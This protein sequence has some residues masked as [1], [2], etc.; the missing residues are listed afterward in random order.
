[1]RSSARPGWEKD[2]PRNA[3][4]TPASARRSSSSGSVSPGGEPD[5]RDR[6]VGRRGFPVALRGA[7]DDEPEGEAAARAGEHRHASRDDRD[8]FGIV[9]WVKTGEIS[10][11]QFLIAGLVI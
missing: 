5:P 4:Q 8:T 3:S 10:T 11:Y 7:L 9:Y 1:L 2:R 6:V